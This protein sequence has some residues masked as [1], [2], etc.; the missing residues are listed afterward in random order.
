[1]KAE[2]SEHR[3]G[4]R[5]ATRKDKHGRPVPVRASRDRPLKFFFENVPRSRLDEAMQLSG[6]DRLY[7]L[8]DAFHDDAYRRTSPGTLCRRFGISLQDLHDL[9]RR[10]NLSLGMIRMANHLPDIMGDLAEDSLSR[11]EVCLRC[12][13][14]RAVTDGAAERN[15]PACEGVGRVRLPGDAHA[16]RLLFEI[17]GLIGP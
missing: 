17:I 16:R 15:C 6:D 12:D 1:M 9:W 13:G 3:K 8:Y 5:P 7:R 4:G 14:M 10:H 2:A 11:D